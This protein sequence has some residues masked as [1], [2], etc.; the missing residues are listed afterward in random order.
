M[1][2]GYAEHADHPHAPSLRLKQ[3]VVVET[4]PRQTWLDDTVADRV[5]GFALGVAPLLAFVRDA[6]A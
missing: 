1:P 3:L 5:A 2:R 4:L 6:S